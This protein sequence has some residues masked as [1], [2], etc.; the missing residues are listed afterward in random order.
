MKMAPIANF[1]RV[2]R[3]RI[4]ILILEKIALV[5][6]RGY[7]Q[8]SQTDTTDDSQFLDLWGKWLQGSRNPTCFKV[9]MAP[10]I[11]GLVFPWGLVVPDRALAQSLEG[12]EARIDLLVGAQEREVEPPR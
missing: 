2:A 10:K 11:D 5:T 3:Q 6:W 12:V 4:S 8:P 1:W 9:E 7:H